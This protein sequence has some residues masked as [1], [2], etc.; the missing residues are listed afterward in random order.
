MSRAP[1]ALC[2]LAFPLAALAAPAA[3]AT[4][5]DPAGKT[6]GRATFEPDA[7]GLRLSVRVEGLKPGRHGI[8]LHAVGACAGPDFK[9]AG[10]HLNPAGKQHGLENPAGHHAG[11]L[12][13][14]EVGA[15]GIAQAS[16]ALAG[17][18]VGEGDA[19]LFHA[20]GTSVVIHADPDDGK[21]DPSGGS[22]ARVA[23]GVVVKP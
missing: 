9:T 21:T 15:D 13:N 19:A 1:L 8:H 11:D 18:T 12:P 23:C 10:G 5:K 16:L 14:L 22:G 3:V 4:L 17:V 2:L 6:I 20:G 7:G